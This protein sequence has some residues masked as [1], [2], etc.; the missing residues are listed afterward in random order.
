[1]SLLLSEHFS[2]LQYFVHFLFTEN[3]NVQFQSEQFALS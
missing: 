3:V 2:L 1:M